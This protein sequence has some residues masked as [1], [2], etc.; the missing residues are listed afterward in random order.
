MPIRWLRWWRRS[1][2]RCGCSASMSVAPDELYRHGLSRQLF[3]P[4]IALLKQHVR[5]VTLDGPTDY[6]RLKFE[7]EAVYH[8]GTGPDIEAEM[9]RLWL[10]LTGGVPGAP[11]EL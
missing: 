1:S 8:F 6:R 5:V 3:T 4:F 9:D 11:A 2:S 7:G 10:R